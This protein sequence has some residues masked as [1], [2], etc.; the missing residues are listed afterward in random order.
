MK[1]IL[2]ILTSISIGAL[3]IVSAATKIYPMEPFEYQFVDIGITNWKTAPYFAR[4]FIAVEFFLGM[5]LIFN[6]S[7]KRFTLKFAIALLL[8]FIGYLGYRIYT[9]GNVGNCGCFG[10]YINMSPLEGILKNL[11]L[12]I[13]CCSLFF[14][15]ENELWKPIYKKI[16]IPILSIGALCLAFFIYPINAVLSSQLDTKKINY[17][18]PIELMYDT[19]QQEKPTIDLL[20]GKHIIA[21]LSLTC[22]HCKIAAQK[23]HVMQKINTKIPFYIAL[24]GD[25][26]LE[27]SFFEDT[28][29]QNIP[30]HLFLGPNAWM[31]VA[32]FNLPVI[33]YINNSI[34]EKKTTGLDLDQTDIENWLKK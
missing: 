32:G 6:I 1:K 9:T 28:Q 23:I 12:I 21:F 11:M 19:I 10:E 17:K 24:N 18:V 29:T 3:F 26:K 31:Q 22:P 27:K 16:L 30:H 5:M 2:L 20:H 15:L 25:K 14:M 8:F 34:V 33:M 4:F 7:L 13:A